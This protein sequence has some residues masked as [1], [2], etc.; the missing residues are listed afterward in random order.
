[1][2]P[3]SGRI[4]A[5]APLVFNDRIYIDIANNAP[6]TTEGAGVC[7]SLAGRDDSQIYVSAGNV[8]V[9]QSFEPSPNRGSV[10]FA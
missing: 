5:I 7:S 4:L 9:I 10:R 3:S 6:T 1:M 2:K 8:A